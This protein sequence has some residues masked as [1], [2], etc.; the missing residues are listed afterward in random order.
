MLA[1]FCRHTMNTK[2][3]VAWNGTSK[4]HSSNKEN[5]KTVPKQ[6]G[7]CTSLRISANFTMTN[8]HMKNT[9]NKVSIY[10]IYNK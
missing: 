5:P 3:I 1:Y 6:I 7:H 2:N 4:Y 8:L 9:T 10:D